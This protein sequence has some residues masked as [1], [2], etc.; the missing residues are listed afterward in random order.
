MILSSIFNNISYGKHAIIAPEIEPAELPD[1]ILGNISY[2][3]KAL[4]K[5]KWYIPRPPPPLKTKPVLPIACLVS[6]I[7]SSFLFKVN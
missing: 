5:P 6:M 3:N 1:M 4:T 2:A 7:N